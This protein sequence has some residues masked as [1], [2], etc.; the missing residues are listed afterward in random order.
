MS[1]RQSVLRVAATAVALTLASVAPPSS[2]IAGSSTQT[3]YTVLAADNLSL[4]DAATA[5]TNAG[6]TIVS[7]NSDVGMFHVVSSASGFEAK[8]DASPQLAGA[9]QQ[10][11]IGRAPGNRPMWSMSGQ[12]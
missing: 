11:V 7:R 12:R 4:A 2:A 8:A 1:R 3:E 5:I 6:G 10:I 9:A